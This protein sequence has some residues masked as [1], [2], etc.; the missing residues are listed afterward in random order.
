MKSEQ[1]FG[2]K[3]KRRIREWQLGVEKGREQGMDG[4]GGNPRNTENKINPGKIAWR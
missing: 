3:Q 4:T 2:T 1:Q